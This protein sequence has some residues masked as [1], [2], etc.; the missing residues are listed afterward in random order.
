MKLSK[1]E[2]SHKV[3]L[4]RPFLRPYRMSYD[5]GTGQVAIIE[6]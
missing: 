3:I 2:Q 4:G 1:G 5:G 6:D